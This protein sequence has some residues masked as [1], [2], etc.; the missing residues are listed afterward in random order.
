M[1]MIESPPRSKTGWLAALLQKRSRRGWWAYVT[2]LLVYAPTVMVFAGDTGASARQMWPFLIPVPILVLQWVRPTILVWAVISL[3]TFLYLGIY[4]YYAI[5]V[6]PQRQ[7]ISEDV[8]LRCVFFSALLGAS[9]ALMAA[10]KLGA[11]RETRAD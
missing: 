6:G 2:W 1:R 5:T 4:S 8:I 10:A 7:W 3:P 9:V 11:F